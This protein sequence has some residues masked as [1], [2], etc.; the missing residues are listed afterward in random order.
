MVCPSEHWRSPHANGR[1]CG[2]LPEVAGRSAAPQVEGRVD[3]ANVPDASGATYPLVGD[4]VAPA[5][6]RLLVLL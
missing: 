1:L 5:L 2:T 4:S 3:L 6:A